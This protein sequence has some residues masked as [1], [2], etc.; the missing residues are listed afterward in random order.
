MTRQS[1]TRNITGILILAA[2]AVFLLNSLNVIA[3]D[4]L[5][6][7]FWPLAIIAAGVLILVNN[8]RS[9]AVAVF[10]VALGSLYQLRELE[11]IDVQPWSV[12]W[13]LILIL[14]G[15][16]I[17]FSHSYTGRRV[18]KAERDDVT[19]IMAGANVKNHSKGFK[20][21]N[22]IAIMGGAQLDLRE[23][24]FDKEAVVEVFGFWGGVDIVVPENVIVR[25]QV[26]NIM[27]GTDDK[28]KQKTDKNSPVL[29][30]IGTMVMSGMSIRNT[31][32]DWQ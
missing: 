31:P 26:L 7:D 23:A 22:A 6:A 10:L 25:N 30:V 18:S 8:V 12:V 5:I 27:A 16:S 24:E 2:G 21:S 11:V 29:T 19:A 13:P 4:N 17:I 1:L 9:W 20:Q 14:V 32:S 28:T 15:V 3:V